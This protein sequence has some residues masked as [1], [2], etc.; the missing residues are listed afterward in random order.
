MT[1]FS[2][3]VIPAKLASAIAIGSAEPGPKG[4]AWDAAAL[5]GCPTLGV[6]LNTST[7]PSSP[8]ALATPTP[9]P[10]PQ[11]GGEKKVFSP[12]TAFW[13][14]LTPTLSP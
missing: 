13:P 10:S 2:A 14:P 5:L 4:H 9:D 11:G 7:A 12:F 8:T 3:V 1:N 6:D